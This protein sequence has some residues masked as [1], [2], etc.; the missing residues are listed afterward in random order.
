MNSLADLSKPAAALF[1]LLALGLGGCNLAPRYSRPSVDVPGRFKEAASAR[2]APGTAGSVATGWKLAQPS[3]DRLGGSWW[4]LFGD[5]DLAALERRVSV[6]NQNIA[7]AAAAYRQARALA[8]EARSSWFPTIGVG[9]SVTRQRS[10][11][12]NFGGSGASSG[13]GGGS[14][15]AP[16]QTRTE[17]S[18]PA[19]ASYELDLWGRIRN[20]V[21]ESA[22]A[23]EA[24]AADLQ[25]AILSTQA[26]LA[27]DYY[28]LRAADEQR[29]ILDTTLADYQA[30][31][32][33]VYTLFHAGLASDE[34]LAQANTQLDTAQAEATD[35]GIARAQYEHAIAVLLGLPPARFSLPVKRFD[36]KLPQIPVALPSQ[37]LERRPDIAAGERRV[38]AANAAI[39]VARAA[40][41][42][43]VSL[44]GSYGYDSTA[45]AQWLDWPNRFWSL[46][47]SAA[48]TVFEGGLRRAQ[49]AAARAAYDQAVASYRQIVLAAFQSVEDDLVTLR[50][51]GREGIQ[52]HDAAEHARHAVEL[53]VARYRDGIDSYVN[54]ITAQ[55]TFL[56]SRLAELQVQLRRIAAC[57]ALVNNLGG[58]WD[59]AQMAATERT[60]EHPQQAAGAAPG[61]SAEAAPNPP[62]LPGPPAKPEELLQQDLEDM[63]PS[64]SPRPVAK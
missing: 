37:I 60:A 4:T 15:G 40:Y 13:Q 55:N 59:L 20:G 58:G 36:P 50:I 57:I 33:L 53:S 6:S 11:A 62:P 38:A 19:D 51:L 48:E 23:A 8:A 28:E 32:R 52:Q 25:T 29:R 10:S 5:P 14:G 2:A 49:N 27:E 42:P 56:A 43:T 17:F 21:A 54:V 12:S 31:L 47:A 18:L 35:L 7:S 30:S 63:G 45:F 3:E 24:G 26:E 16:G 44:S 41:F 61:E 22:Y 64:P 1:A 34:D 39:G 9:P 46:G